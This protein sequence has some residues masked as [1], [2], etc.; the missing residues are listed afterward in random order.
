MLIVN[1]I[2]KNWRN[3]DIT[4]CTAKKAIVSMRE[5]R[6]LRVRDTFNY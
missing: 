1:H 3:A 5:D 4:G 2:T 6:D